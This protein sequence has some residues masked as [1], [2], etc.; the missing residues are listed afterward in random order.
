MLTGGGGEILELVVQRVLTSP[1]CSKPDWTGPE[2]PEL[3]GPAVSG[4]GRDG[5]EKVIRCLQM[6]HLIGSQ[7]IFLG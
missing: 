7:Y 2:Q 1:S 5:K 4:F 6:K 3:V